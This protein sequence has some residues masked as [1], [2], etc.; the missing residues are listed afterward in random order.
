MVT[1]TGEIEMG[2]WK[3]VLRAT[4][5]EFGLVGRAIAERLGDSPLAPSSSSVQSDHRADDGILYQVLTAH[6]QMW[7]TVRTGPM[8]SDPLGVL[9]ATTLTDLQRSYP[10]CQV[11]AV[12]RDGRLVDISLAL[13]N[14]KHAHEARGMRNIGSFSTIS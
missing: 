10:G 2:F 7:E 4:L 12:T 8:I 13:A 3:S 11:R 1:K 14:F 5:G 6:G 9:V